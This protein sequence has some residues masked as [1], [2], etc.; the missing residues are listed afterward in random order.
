MDNKVCR[1]CRPAAGITAALALVAVVAV[2]CSFE[3][4]QGGS[5]LKLSLDFDSRMLEWACPGESQVPG[6]KT[7]TPSEPWLPHSYSVRGTGPGGKTFSV[8]CA[9]STFETKLDPG[10]WHI[11]ADALG[12]SG[13]TVADGAGDFVLVA[14]LPQSGK[15][16]LAPI[17]GEGSL[18]LAISR[19]YDVPTGSR[20]SGSLA[21]RSLP[22]R[23]LEGTHDPVVIDIPASDTEYSIQAL[24]AGFY[25]ISL[26]LKTAEGQVLS[27][28]AETIL[29]LADFETSGSCI[30]ALGCP[31]IILGTEIWPYAPLPD[32]ILSCSHHM[33]AKFRPAV[34]GSFPGSPDSG[35]SLLTGM[36]VQGSESVAGLRITGNR[37]FIPG[38]AYAFVPDSILPSSTRVRIDIHC[39][40][41]DTG[42][43]GSSSVDVFPAP[44]L[45]GGKAEWRSSYDFLGA[46]GPSLCRGGAYNSGSGQ[47]AAVKAVMASE[48]GLVAVS[49]L[50][51]DAAIHI[52]A[53]ASDAMAEAVPGGTETSLPAGSSWMRLW[54]DRV[55]VNSS[56]RSA[57]RIA[58]SD[59]CR[60][61]AA[62]N[63]SSNWLRIYTLDICGEISGCIDITATD[64]GQGDN[65]AGFGNIC[66][67]CFS[68]DSRTLYAL[69]KSGPAVFAFD[70][71][72]TEPVFREKLLLGETGK[73]ACLMTRT[74]KGCLAVAAP[75]AGKVLTVL[76]AAPLAIGAV[77]NMTD[78][79]GYATM[80]AMTA[81]L[82]GD[83]FW[84]LLGGK[85]V[86]EFRWDEA[87]GQYCR[88]NSYTLPAAL[89]GSASMCR[90]L[91]KSLQKEILFIAGTKGIGFCLINPYGGLFASALIPPDT[92]NLAGIATVNGCAYA[93]GEFMISGGKS[94]T[95]SVFYF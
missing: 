56:A 24:P 8:S 26:Q 17:A 60:F 92:S 84:L 67:L 38:N 51:D 88:G 45:A 3:W 14:G 41:A 81:F 15:I 2:S 89:A 75:A 87:S 20:L 21:Y 34:I 11:E 7:L 13:K 78:I 64:A 95:A 93:R 58:I 31:E 68:A 1:S 33:N 54:R 36:Y 46:M 6:G 62:A 47:A 42:Q 4:P 48:G 73:G 16:P 37:G 40:N 82:G 39:A 43:R 27:G 52:F 10:E 59:D 25:T 61:V 12:E 63:S 79:P 65:L 66:A 94:G 28:M 74:R 49:G 85:T 18:H 55:V 83:S 72:G 91:S 80:D 29:I 71:G 90:G 30:I 69:S 53:S 77:I 9:E 22:G 57:D 5:L 44:A 70:L 19:N 86:T 35:S 76:D 32:P 50:D 23:P